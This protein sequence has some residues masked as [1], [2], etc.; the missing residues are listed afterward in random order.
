MGGEYILRKCKWTCR[1]ILLTLNPGTQRSGPT[2]RTQERTRMQATTFLVMTVEI[3]ADN[4]GKF[5]RPRLPYPASRH[6][7]QQ[8]WDTCAGKNS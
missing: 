7:P 4:L 5:L 8:K 6:L 1:P 2:S 3:L